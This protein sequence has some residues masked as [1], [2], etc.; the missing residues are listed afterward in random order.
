MRTLGPRAAGVGHEINNL[1][2]YVLAN[3]EFVLGELAELRR[4]ETLPPA[5]AARLGASEEALRDAHDG[6]GR[7]RAI[8]GDLLTLSRGDEEVAGPVEVVRAVDAAIDLA[9]NELRDRARLVRSCTALPAVMA[10]EPR[11]V[12]VFTN[13]LLNAAHAMRAGWLEANELRV[14]AR[15]DGG[16]V[17]IEFADTGT[18]IAPE[19]LPLIFDPFFTTKPVGEGSG[20]GLPVSR[21]IVRAMGGEIHVHSVL[22]KGSVFRVELPASEPGPPAHALAEPRGGAPAR[23]ARVLVVDDEPRVAS[24]LR[25][26]LAAEHDLVDAS[27]PRLALAMLEAGERFDVVLCDVLLP[28]MR[29]EEFLEAVAARS[30]ELASR[31]ALVTGGALTPDAQAF[32]GR[33]P[34]RIL[35]KPFDLA[36]VRALVA[37]LTGSPRE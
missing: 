29:A 5:G 18:G 31:V 33:V 8:A 26:L 16:R 11:L 37:E 9:W 34:N 28:E 17:V 22:G 6:A 36:T 12:Q 15:A 4:D 23:R 10:S 27:S 21:D 35:Q 24:V 25:R 30:A 2:S 20:L 7:I 14:T 13:L 1:L 3:L 19:H 32:L